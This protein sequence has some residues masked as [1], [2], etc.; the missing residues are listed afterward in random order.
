M[1]N[2]VKD[3]TSEVVN[4]DGKETPSGETKDDVSSEG[5]TDEETPETTT[6]DE[7]VVVDDD[8][9]E[10]AEGRIQAVL[11]KLGYD[12]L[13]E[14]IEDFDSLKELQDTIGDKDAKK[15]VE[16]AEYLAKVKEFWKQQDEAKKR[17]SETHDETIERL[18]R[19]KKEAEDKLLERDKKDAKKK[20]QIE[21][22]KKAEK[23]LKSF[24]STV[25][26][27]IDKVKDIPKEYRP[28]LQEFLGVDNPA[29]EINIGVRPEVRKMA[30]DGIKKFYDLEQIIIK[31]YV[32][33]KI[34]TPKI[35]PAEETPVNDEVKPKNLKE[36]RNQL[37][38][39]FGIKR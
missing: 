22:A 9:V 30:K 33:G 32:D 38:N 15:L 35:T 19:E 36:A 2:L 17:E 24:N 29:N 16:D 3:G 23:L 18:E 6:D 37:F 4:D 12:D 26:A 39:L 10:G 34:K 20:E 28:F 25:L 31:R 27:E 1:K 11:D 21:Q 7:D 13:E 14:L 5:A 8:E